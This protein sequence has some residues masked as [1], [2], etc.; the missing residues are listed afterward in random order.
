M[1]L[2]AS[3]WWVAGWTVTSPAE[4]QLGPEHRH[5]LSSLAAHL[6]HS[7]ALWSGGVLVATQ[8]NHQST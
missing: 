5:P 6:L 3:S 4:R 8:D 7:T 1:R 2:A